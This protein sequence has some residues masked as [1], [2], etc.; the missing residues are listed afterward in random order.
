MRVTVPA[1]GL[2][3]KVS[4]SSIVEAAHHLHPGPAIVVRVGMLAGEGGVGIAHDPAHAIVVRLDVFQ[5]DGIAARSRNRLPRNWSGG[6]SISLFVV[7]EYTVLS[8]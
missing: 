6:S 2:S 1:P 4:A 7:I 3:Q 8:L 5:G